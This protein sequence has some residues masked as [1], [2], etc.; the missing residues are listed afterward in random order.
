MD[1]KTLREACNEQALR[2]LAFRD[3]KPSNTV[4]I[5]EYRDWLER[6]CRDERAAAEV[7]DEAL[8]LDKRPTI[9]DLSRIWNQLHPQQSEPEI[10]PEEREARRE[11]LKRWY[12]EEQREGEVRRAATKAWLEKLAARKARPVRPP[13]AK[14]APAETLRPITQEDIDR[15]AGEY[16]KAKQEKKP[17]GEP[18]EPV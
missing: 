15:A 17:N 7:I 9:A 4:A 8:N 14:P 3:L 6:H 16:E 10:T 1:P 11:W 13:L 18:S 5:K 2:L 12:A